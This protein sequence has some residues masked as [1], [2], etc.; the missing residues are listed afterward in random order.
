MSLAPGRHSGLLVPLFSMPSRASWGIGEIGDIPF[1]TSWLRGAGQ[2]LLQLLPINEMAVGQ[3]SPYSAMTAMAID[4]ILISVH[5]VADFQAFGGN[6][7]MGHDWQGRLSD[8][9]RSPTIDDALVRSV[10]EP[11]L[12]A[13]FD[14]FVRRH[15]R[16]GTARAHAYQTWAGEQSWWLDDYALFRA[17]HVREQNRGWTHWPAPLRHRDSDALASARRELANEVFYRKWIQWIADTQWHDAKT[18]ARPVSLM[19]DLAFMVDGDS[20]DVWVH[21]AS[22]RLDASVGAPPD[23]FSETGQNWGM[24][25]YRWDVLARR[26]FDWLRQRAC[27]T[28]SLFDGYRV[29]HLVGFY[30]T[31]VFPNDG[32]PAFFTP[33]QEPAQLALGETVLSIFGQAGARIIAEDLGTVPDFVRQSLARLGVPGYKVFRWERHWETKGQ[34]YRDPSAYPATSVATSGTHDTEP[35]AAWWDG[36]DADERATVLA[37]PG[38]AERVARLDD[39]AGE[40]SPALRDVLLEVLFASGSDFLLLPVQDVFGWRGRINT[41]ANHGDHNWTWRLPWPV[42]TLDRV[43]EA[44]ERAE[45]LR[46]WSRRHR[47]A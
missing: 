26:D 34:P 45:T 27:R 9:R 18:Q 22:F 38:V 30:R 36:L 24:P 21:S 14:E 20:A 17:L 33:A 2:D 6:S 25:A 29:D 5:A 8:A 32:A 11:A 31:Y 35:A 1:L 12:R 7:A 43:P 23:A 46:A 19:G 28:A 13:A 4:P 44:R 41:P 40:F 47:R 42:D 16:P 3:R 37:T 10:K 39:A 15:A